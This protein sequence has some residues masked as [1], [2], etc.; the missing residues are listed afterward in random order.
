MKV[1]DAEVIRRLRQRRGLS[2]R[3]LAYLCGCSQATISLIE[4]GEM[5][6]VSEELSQRIAVRLQTPWDDLFVD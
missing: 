4:R 1:R 5:A 6:G 3:D 2:Q